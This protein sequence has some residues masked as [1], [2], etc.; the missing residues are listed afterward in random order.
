MKFYILPESRKEVEKRIEKAS[1]HL[2]QKPTV[3]FSAPMWKTQTT[4]IQWKCDGERGLDRE[5][6]QLEVLEVEVE[7]I[8]ANGWVLVADVHYD[9]GFVS[10]ISSQ[11]YGGIPAQYGL[12]YT[13]CDYCGKRHNNRKLSHIIHKPETGEWMQIGSSCGKYIFN[14]GNLC[15]FT[16]ELY[17]IITCNL[18]C[19]EEFFGGWSI[20]DHSWQIGY[21]VSLMVD[22]VRKYKKEVTDVWSKSYREGDKK[23]PGTNTLV[24]DWYLSQK[25]DHFKED[26]RYTAKVAKY[27]ATLP[28]DDEQWADGAFEEGFKSGIKRAFAEGYILAS[29]IFRVWFAIKMYEESLTLGDWQSKAAQYEVGSKI[30]LRGLELCSTIRI[31]D[32]YYGPSVKS[33]FKTKDGMIIEKSSSIGASFPE[34]YK[35]A[36]GTYSFAATV[37]YI[38]EKRRVIKLGGRASKVK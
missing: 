18:G 14:N 17:K 7:D 32:F 27:V 2:A 6:K 24:F 4:M 13:K 15:Q 37:K 5:R 23:I 16:I 20:P 25:A 34:E 26:E 35:Q 36:D 38:N 22:V 21:K 1:K 11:Y 28:N 9:E 31:E 29:E 33:T 30:Q 3:T 8:T 10:M 12:Q 19:C